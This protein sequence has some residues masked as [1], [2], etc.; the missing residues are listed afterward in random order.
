MA[1]F[2]QPSK[3]EV[4]ERR[5][6]LADRA[7]AGELKLP[8]AIREMRLALGLSQ[9][10]FAEL[11]RMTRRQVAE[12]ERGEANPTIETLD[13]IGR[14]FGFSVGFVPTRERAPKLRD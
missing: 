12:I 5:H 1:R 4:Y 11:F 14:A 7:A 9:Q 10:T 8:G 2:R 3:E 13:R 6:A